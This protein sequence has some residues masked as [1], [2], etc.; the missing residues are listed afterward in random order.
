[1]DRFVKTLGFLVFAKM[2]LMKDRQD[3]EIIKRKM[4]RQDANLMQDFV[5][6]QMEKN[7]EVSV[8]AFREDML[9]AVSS[10]I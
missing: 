3:L 4:S 6:E 9:S 1:S 7:S 2:L 5:N 10:V 8:I